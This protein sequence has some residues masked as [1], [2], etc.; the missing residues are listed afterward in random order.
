MQ[1]VTLARVKI[2]DGSMFNA[3]TKGRVAVTL[4][5]HSTRP[6]GSMR[7]QNYRL[8]AGKVLQIEKRCG[9]RLYRQH[10]FSVKQ[11]GMENGK[12][13]EVF[14]IDRWM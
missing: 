4:E 2:A 1:L 9:C 13:V 12:M 11:C 8:A 6:H 7:H 10:T 3:V 5:M 14:Q